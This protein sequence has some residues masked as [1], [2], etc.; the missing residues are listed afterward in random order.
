MLV[1]VAKIHG[2]SF[3]PVISDALCEGHEISVLNKRVPRVL[4]FSETGGLNKLLDTSDHIKFH[5]VEH[6]IGD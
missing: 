1:V 4:C 6:C 5:V 3:N 2:K